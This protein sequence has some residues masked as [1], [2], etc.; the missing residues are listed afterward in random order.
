MQV[1]SLE[2]Q[3]A[4]WPGTMQTATNTTPVE[5]AT[6]ADPTR[7][8]LA[9]A[10]NLLR[11]CGYDLVERFGH[12]HATRDAQE[13]HLCLLADLASMPPARLLTCLDGALKLRV[14]QSIALSPHV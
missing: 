9:T 1:A 13:W 4:K 10:R 3:R 7:L 8:D 2:E 14:E 12:V 11:E 6:R 5:C